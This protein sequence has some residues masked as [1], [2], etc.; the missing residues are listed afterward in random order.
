MMRLLWAIVG[1]LTIVYLLR[2]VF[3]TVFHPRGTG[4]IGNVVARSTWRIF[5][6]FARYRSELL[7]FAGPLTLL[8][9]IAVWTALL[10]AG[11][12]L[13]YFAYLSQSTGTSVLRATYTSFST[14]VT[15]SA[16]PEAER[17]GGLR[18]L[19]PLEA[20]I[21]FGLFTASISWVLS[22][23]PVVSRRRNLASEIA[24]LCRRQ[25]GHS[26]P[27]CRCNPVYVAVTLHALAKQFIAAR[28][29]LMQFPITYYFHAPESYDDLPV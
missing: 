25:E 3:H 12:A 20:L 26:Q 23:Y 11:W 13:I 15:L 17:L 29:D 14:L 9:V 10:V 7:P 27:L 18:L 16:G 4:S 1:V 19:L 28:S 24:S 22:T 21:G 8:L 5:R 6:S 2:D